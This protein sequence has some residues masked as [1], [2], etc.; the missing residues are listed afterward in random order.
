LESEEANGTSDV[1]GPSSDFPPDSDCEETELD[2]TVVRKQYTHPFTM[3][4]KARGE[5]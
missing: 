1:V 3:V 4:D 5:L 2:A